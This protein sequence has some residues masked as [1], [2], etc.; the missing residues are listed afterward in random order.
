MK[1]RIL[2]AVLVAVCLLSLLGGC[3]NK[4]KEVVGSCAGYDVLY[5]E[6]RFVAQT[7][8]EKEKD[9]T[10]EELWRAVADQI[11][12]DYAVT[13]AAKAVF[14]ELTMESAEIQTAVDAAVNDAIEEYG[15]KSKYK[16]FLKENRLTESYARLLLGRA[17]IELR[18]REQLE[19]SLFA[20]TELENET[21]FSAWLQAGNLVRARRITAKSEATVQAV[22]A[23]MAQGKT[24]EEAVQGRSDVELSSKF[25]LVRG[26]S[27]DELLEVDAFSLSEENPIGEIRKTGTEYRFLILE[28]NDMESFTAYQLPTYYKNMRAEK[29]EAEREKAIA[30]AAE[31]NPFV[32][33]EYGSALDLMAL[34]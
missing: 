19:I 27:D 22:R 15:S 14:P 16:S 8:L 33:N 9:L 10:S 6:L 34:K 18:W 21:A 3:A 32:P 23:A 17:E 25:Y 20:G 5:E 4:E 12:A 11:A 13:I 29:S 7:L 24:A 1:I 28:M 30:E 31:K 26:Y 2:S